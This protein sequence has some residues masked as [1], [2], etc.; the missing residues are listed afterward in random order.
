MDARQDVNII[1][2]NICSIFLD[3]ATNFFSG[4]FFAKIFLILILILIFSGGLGYVDFRKILLVVGAFSCYFF[5][6][7]ST[8]ASI[9]ALFT[10]ILFIIALYPITHLYGFLAFIFAD[11]KISF[12]NIKIDIGNS[13]II[14]WAITLFYKP[15]Y[16]IW[17][18]ASIIILSCIFS[19]YVFKIKKIILVV[20]IALI[21]MAEVYQSFQ[22][23]SIEYFPD[24]KSN[25]KYRVGDNLEEN[26]G[27]IKYEINK[28]AADT[29]IVSLYTHPNLRPESRFQIYLNEHD[30]QTNSLSHLVKGNYRQPE[31]WGN[32]EFIGNQ[33][34]IFA[35]HQDGQLVS[36]YGSEFFGSRD[37]ALAHFNFKK[38]EINCLL[39]ESNNHLI[40][41]DSDAF[42]NSLVPYQNNLINEILYK[43]RS[44]RLINIGFLIIVLAQGTLISRYRVKPLLLIIIFSTQYFTMGDVRLGCSNYW[45]HEKS[46][47]SGFLRLL[48][49]NGIVANKGN[50]N[51]K[52]LIVE[53]NSVA[54]SFGEPLVILQSNSKVFING[55]LIKAGSLPCGIQGEE[56]SDARSLF[57]GDKFLGYEIIRGK[58]KIIGTGSPTR[59]SIE[60]CI[61]LF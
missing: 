51:A 60:K 33:Y 30:T 24:T 11:T 7:K 31:P 40:T 22:K 15:F 42:V 48:A 53:P 32:N 36:N 9:T 59:L 44:A 14:F 34:Y 4:I 3:K 20:T 29:S 8:P 25:Y 23:K 56:I 16:N 21:S 18:L 2:K 35:I 39:Y 45:P 5:N 6:R 41:G 49:E 57:H 38:S 1:K 10:K 28:A 46:S 27:L 55:E 43:S 13:V 47:S 26:F 52:I 50:L 17:L 58:T 12:K 19:C 37:I 54:I 61:H